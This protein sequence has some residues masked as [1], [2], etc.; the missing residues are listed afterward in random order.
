MRTG[1]VQLYDPFG[2]SIDLVTG[3]IG[4]LAANSLSLSN[5]VTPSA[6]Y[7]WEGSHSKQTETAGDIDT[8]EMGSRQ[9]VPILGRFPSV[10]SVVGGNSN[11]YNY[12]NDPINSSDLSGNWSWGDT[13]AVVGIVA[14]VVVSVVLT[15]T[16]V[17]SVGDVATGAG[18]AALGGEIA[19]DGAVEASVEGGAEITS[20]AVADGGGEA[21]GEA[22]DGAALPR[23][24][25]ESP[26]LNNIVQNLYKGVDNAE[27]TGNGT[28]MDAVR[29]ELTTGRPVGGTF[30]SIKALESANGLR[31]LLL[32]GGLS[33][34]NSRVANSLLDEIRGILK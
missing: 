27:R 30:H 7:G 13:L 14:L 3:L 24:S 8:V 10:D 18:I 17:G 28:T 1:S 4:T 15:V 22:G 9:Y 31:N 16:V 19:A 32:R 20:E 25:V 2:D 6:N 21:A 26:K 11:A 12:P 33:A 5:T 23:P 34:R 29:S